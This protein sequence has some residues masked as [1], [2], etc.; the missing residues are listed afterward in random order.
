MRFIRFPTSAYTIFM[1]AGSYTSA[2]ISALGPPIFKKDGITAPPKMVGGVASFGGSNRL[3]GTTG[4]PKMV[5]I[6]VSFGLGLSRLPDSEW[7]HWSALSSWPSERRAA[8]LTR[9]TRRR[10][11]SW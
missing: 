9:H 2:S 7:N 11:E 3:E 6:G 10:K 8:L 4:T 5:G 1:P